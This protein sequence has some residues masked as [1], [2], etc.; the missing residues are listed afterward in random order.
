[1]HIQYIYIYIYIYKQKKWMAAHKHQCVIDGVAPVASAKR[2]RHLTAAHPSPPRSG[3]SAGGT[4]GG[5]SG[6]ICVRNGDDDG[7]GGD[8]GWW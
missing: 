4:S 3:V 1:M 7:G 5:S 2:T 8:D 6:L